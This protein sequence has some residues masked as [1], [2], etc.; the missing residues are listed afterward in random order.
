MTTTELDLSPEANKITLDDVGGTVYVIDGSGMPCILHSLNGSGRHG[1]AILTWRSLY[2]NHDKWLPADADP[3]LRG[4]AFD[5]RVVTTSLEVSKT[6][7]GVL[8][9]LGWDLP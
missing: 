4:Q 7:R 1:V 8:K 3:F 9:R 6:P 5:A 2:P